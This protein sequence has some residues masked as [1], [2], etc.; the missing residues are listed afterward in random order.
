MWPTKEACRAGLGRPR[1]NLGVFLAS[2]WREGETGGGEREVTALQRLSPLKAHIVS[3]TQET[4][5]Y[6]SARVDR[7]KPFGQAGALIHVPGNQV[8]LRKLRT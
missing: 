3:I 4:S 2:V 7:R 1:G 5:G 6:P 8:E